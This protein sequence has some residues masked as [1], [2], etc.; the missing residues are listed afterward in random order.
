MK[1][2]AI[3][4]SCYVPWKGYFDIIAGVDEF[5][6]FDDTQYTRRDWRN[7]NRI[8]TPAGLQWLTIGVN[9]KGR[10]DQAIEDT[11]INDE[12]WASRHWKTLLHNYRS[13][14][15]FADYADRVEGLY[16]GASNEHLSLV[17][18]AFLTAICSWLGVRTKITWSRD[19]EVAKNGRTERLVGL[20]T[21]A[22]ATHYLSG[23]SA[24]GYIVPSAFV[25]A[26][27]TLEYMDYSGYP[28]YP[29]LW[30]AFEHG[31]S[32][33]DLLFNAGDAAPRFMKNVAGGER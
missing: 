17:N 23:P 1:R 15:S 18:H 5:I 25:E 3:V 7:R 19:Y 2:V 13:A 20:C 11:T 12:D 30:G 24:Q 8:K 10:Y 28:T 29:Q 26:G 14:P 27:I 9:V 21:A 22:G 33:L 4:Q 31:V 6:L 16:R 32:I